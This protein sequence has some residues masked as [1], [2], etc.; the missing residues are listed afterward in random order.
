MKHRVNNIHCVHFGILAENLYHIEKYAT[1]QGV[2][3][4][5]RIKVDWSLCSCEKEKKDGSQD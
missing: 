5:P 3:E 1:P 2:A 4:G